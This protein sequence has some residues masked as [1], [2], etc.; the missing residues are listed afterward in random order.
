MGHREVRHGEHRMR[1]E[2]GRHSRGLR[3]D[4]REGHSRV[5][6][7]RR[8]VDHVGDLVHTGVVVMGRDSLLEV[9]ETERRSDP[10]HAEAVGEAD[11]SLAEEDSGLVGAE[12]DHREGHRRA[13]EGR[14]VVEDIP[15]EDDL[16][17]EG[18][19]RM[20]ALLPVSIYDLLVLEMSSA[21]RR[22][23]LGSLTVRRR[24]LLIRH[25][26]GVGDMRTE[27]V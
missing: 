15:E 13:A 3:G 24:V 18:I 6:A 25:D 16:A 12:E 2:E 19:R 21:P 20:E 11:R 1:L 7:G 4:R 9:E 27:G 10:V 23:D 26:G 14:G 5:A 8:V 17:E 22:C